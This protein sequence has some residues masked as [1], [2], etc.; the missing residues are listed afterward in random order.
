M[1]ESGRW[2]IFINSCQKTRD[3]HCTL[4]YQGSVV[5]KR[6]LRRSRNSMVW[7][8]PETFSCLRQYFDLFYLFIT[9]SYIGFCIHFVQFLQLLFSY[10]FFQYLSTVSIGF[11]LYFI[12]QY[13]YFTIPSGFS[14]LIVIGLIF[15]GISMIIRGAF[16]Y[17]IYEDLFDEYLEKIDNYFLFWKKRILYRHRLGWNPSDT[18]ENNWVC[19]APHPELLV[20]VYNIAE[21]FWDYSLVFLLN[22]L[23]GIVFLF[24]SCMILIGY[25]LY[26]IGLYLV[27]VLIGCGFILY[28][29][30]FP[31]DLFG[32]F[33]NHHLSQTDLFT[34]HI[35]SW[36]ICL[37]EQY[38]RNVYSVHY[39]LSAWKQYKPNYR[40]LSVVILFLFSHIFTGSR[41]FILLD[42][43][44]YL[45]TEQS[46]GRN[47]HT[48]AHTGAGA[49]K[50][51]H[52]EELSSSPTN[53]SDD[54]KEFI[55]ENQPFHLQIPPLCLIFMMIEC[56]CC[57]TGGILLGVEYFPSWQS[58]VLLAT[59]SVSFLTDIFV[60][61]RLYQT[62]SFINRVV[63]VD[64]LEDKLDN[65][66]D[67][68]GC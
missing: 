13:V 65:I 53:K 63:V 27:L 31:I 24:V 50:Y 15:F 41:A 9:S 25:V 5:A 51:L 19:L 40:P 16:R 68:E 11:I 54:D 23:T 36:L 33:I 61:S 17:V 21:F 20:F 3:L 47:A 32:A 30:L 45:S 26:F 22:T 48:S 44:S 58:Y 56:I 39:P 46:W 10:H 35:L 7:F 42:D 8:D 29:G 28:L 6:R 37:L 12:F 2:Y 62:R 4:L 66:A 60:F 34:F 49:R 43:L 14:Q 38:L 18:L 1:P 59:I 52:D 64:K 57:T 55:D 67:D